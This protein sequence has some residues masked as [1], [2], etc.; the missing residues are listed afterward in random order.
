MALTENRIASTA[1]DAAAIAELHEIVDRQRAAFLADPYP[2]AGAAPRAARRARRDADRPPRADPGGDERRLR[3]PPDARHRHDRDPRGRR[4]R[5]LRR[6]AP[7]RSGWRPSRAH[8]DPAL[9]RHRPRLRAAP[10]QGRDRQHRPLELPVRS[11]GRAARRDARRRQPGRDQAVGVRAGLRASC[12]GTWS[13]RRSIAIA[14]TSSSAGWSS[15]RTFPTLRWDHLLYTGSPAIGREIAKA[16][17]ENLVPV[18]L[19][20]G[21]KCPAIL[22]ADSVDAESVEAGA[23]HQVAQERPDVHLGRLLP[24]AARPDG[25]VRELARRARARHDARLLARPT[26][27]P[28]S[29]PSATSSGSSALLEEARAARLRHPAARGGRTATRTRRQLPMSLVI[30]PP[31]ISSSCRRR[32][33][34][35]SCRSSPTTTLDEAIAYVNA[36]ERP[37]GAV[38][39]RQ[40]RGVADRVLRRTTSGGACVNAAAVHGALAV[41]AVRRHRPERHRPPPR[42]RGLPRVLEPRAAVRPRRRRP[43]RG[44]HAAVWRDRPGRR[45]RSVLRRRVTMGSSMVTASAAP[46][47]YASDADPAFVA[48]CHCNDCQRQ[49]GAAHSIVAVFPPTRSRSAARTT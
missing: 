20:L 42:R 14:S 9:L 32:S 22:T 19:E 6:R 23:G 16:A 4:P 43:D 8:A 10:A 37:L 35:R 28:G 46:S 47:A 12:C 25:G 34:A 18:T 5:R 15:R 41:A 31:T 39:V 3:R 24:G 45:Q 27:A 1:D 38:R 17:A 48:I 40:G 21:G 30:D 29:S 36:G 49:T 26:T 13:A 44:V 33:S 11:V 2:D 7:R